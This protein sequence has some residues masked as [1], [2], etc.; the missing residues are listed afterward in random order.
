[1]L[2]TL[3]RYWLLVPIL[4][5]LATQCDEA[6]RGMPPT[7]VTSIEVKLLSLPAPLPADMQEFDNCLNRMQRVNHIEPSWRAGKLVPFVES[8][9]NIFTVRFFD[10]PLDFQNT[11]T[12]H[13]V[14]ECRRDPKAF[15][16]VTTGV[17][18]NG[19]PVTQVVGTGVLV[20][21]VSSDGVV[22]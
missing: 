12:V 22:Q 3:R 14:N 19:T 5:S 8:G 11:M 13:D 20:F 10:V 21:I 6:P 2:R 18:V 17:T 9:P 15:G 1:M 4:T 16:H 7:V